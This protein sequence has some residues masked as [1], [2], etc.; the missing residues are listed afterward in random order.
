MT[1]RFRWLRSW[2]GHPGGFALSL[3][4]RLVHGVRA[5]DGALE[6]AQLGREVGSLARAPAQ[7]ATGDHEAALRWNVLG[8]AGNGR[9]G[10]SMDGIRPFL[11]GS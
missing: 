9:Q 11:H 8:A 3:F 4:R 2:V 7:V 5:D 10:A 1:P 6:L